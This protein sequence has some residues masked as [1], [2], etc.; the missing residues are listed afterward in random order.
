M[1]S[2]AAAGHAMGWDHDGLVRGFRRAFVD[3]LP[4]RYDL[5]V[6]S[7]FS[8]VQGDRALQRVFEDAQIE[9]LW[10]SC[11]CVAAN[12][13]RAEAKVFRRGPVWHAVRASG[14]FPGLLPPVP[15]RGELLVDGGLLDNVPVA[16][17][18]GLCPGP[19]IASDV[20]SEVELEVDPDLTLSP[21]P[22]RHLRSRLGLSRSRVQFPGI[23]PVILRSLECREVADRAGRRRAAALYLTPPVAGFGL[24]EVKRLEAIVAAGYGYALQ[25]F[26]ELPPSFPRQRTD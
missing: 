10:T 11:F 15:E 25:R 2:F 9:D 13:T 5:P 7:V 23:V 22:G 3:T 24:M 21:S 18:Q 14:S 20:S 17:M 8:P 16:L 19:V 1:G 26:R 4:W 12:I 6:F